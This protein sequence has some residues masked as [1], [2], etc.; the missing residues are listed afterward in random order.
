MSAAGTVV[1]FPTPVVLRIL[2]LRCS[3]APV[4]YIYDAT[5]DVEGGLLA[6]F[7]PTKAIRSSTTPVRI[8]R[9]VVRPGVWFCLSSLSIAC[10][11]ISFLWGWSFQLGD[12]VY[13]S[14]P[15]I[16]PFCNSSTCFWRSLGGV[17]PWF[18]ARRRLGRGGCRGQCARL[19]SN[20]RG[21][22]CPWGDIHTDSGPPWLSAGSCHW[23]LGPRPP[24]SQLGRPYVSGWRWRPHGCI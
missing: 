10:R 15:H 17:R 12:G 5:P 14:V 22:R 21:S 16:S 8:W 24:P 3:P 4:G 7:S 19:C 11:T 1:P 18:R 6:G 23:G 13:G 9:P 20:Q 2:P